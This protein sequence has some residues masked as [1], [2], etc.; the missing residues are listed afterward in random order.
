MTRSTSAVAFS[1]SIVSFSCF[2]RA[3]SF[4]C[5]S[6]TE[7]LFWRA[8]VGAVLRFGLV[9]LRC[10]AFVDFRLTVPRRVT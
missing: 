1:R 6:A 2:V 9:G 4:S 5:R 7:R 8:A 10:C 3:S